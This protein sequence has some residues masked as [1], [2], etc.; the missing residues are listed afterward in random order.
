MD[1]CRSLHETWPGI[2]NRLQLVGLKSHSSPRGKFFKL[3]KWSEQ[4]RSG[5]SVWLGAVHRR[6]QIQPWNFA[7][8]EAKE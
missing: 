8:C 6:V 1:V 5:D 7:G 2:S 3:V 4:L